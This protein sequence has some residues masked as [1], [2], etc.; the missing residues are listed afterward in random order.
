MD[1]L[2]LLAL[3]IPKRVSIWFSSS[4]RFY[5]I[6]LFQSEF[7][8]NYNNGGNEST[9]ITASLGLTLKQ[10]YSFPLNEKSSWWPWLL[11]FCWLWSFWETWSFILTIDWSDVRGFWTVQCFFK[12]N[13][14]TALDRMQLLDMALICHLSL[15]IIP[16]QQNPVIICFKLLGSKMIFVFSGFLVQRDCFVHPR[17][18]AAENSGS[19][20][21][22]LP[23]SDVRTVR[24][25]VFPA[26]LWNRLRVLPGV[27]LLRAD[28]RADQSGRL[29][30]DLLRHPRRQLHL[31]DGATQG[32]RLPAE[33]AAGLLPEPPAEP[34]NSVTKVFRLLLLQLQR[35]KCPPGDHEQPAALRP[36][37]ASQV[38]PQGVDL[39][40]EGKQVGRFFLFIF[41][42]GQI[43]SPNANCPELKASLEVV[44]K[45][46]HKVLI[47]LLKVLF[48]YS[49]KVSRVF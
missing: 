39:Q 28:G 25:P 45:A 6:H 34:S 5:L 2:S 16:F 13:K 29:R 7:I 12:T 47:I 19:S 15:L 44:L 37:D 20:L 35:Q 36:P 8:L 49:G 23:V 32:G 43:E 27:A 3:Q 14:L 18:L 21:F 46:S 17:R 40:A 9:A 26:P 30:V 1:T 42:E 10:F 41:K 22:R 48:D 38:R 33:A 24:V 31:Q 4:V 11:P